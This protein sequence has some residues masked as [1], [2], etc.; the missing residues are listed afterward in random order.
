MVKSDLLTCSQNVQTRQTWKRSLE[1]SGFNSR[2]AQILKAC[3]CTIPPNNPLSV[4]KTGY[5]LKKK[6]HNDSLRVA[7]ICTGRVKISFLYSAEDSGDGIGYAC[8]KAHYD[9][10]TGGTSKHYCAFPRCKNCRSIFSRQPNHLLLPPDD[11]LILNVNFCC[12]LALR[13][14]PAIGKV[15]N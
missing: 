5:P 14:A 9:H 11:P 15:F 4:Y 13:K 12:R 7:Y 8:I 10:S 2:H 6:H 1:R 3:T